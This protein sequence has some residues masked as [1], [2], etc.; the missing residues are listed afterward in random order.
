MM[1]T[2]KGPMIWREFPAKIVE[3]KAHKLASDFANSTGKESWAGEYADEH[4]P[5]FMMDALVELSEEA[6]KQP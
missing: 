2:I 1:T 5:D 6:S 4:W 3:Q